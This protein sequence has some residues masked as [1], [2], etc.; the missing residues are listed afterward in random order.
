MLRILLIFLFIY[1]CV[2]VEKH[3]LDEN[4][5]EE[6]NFNLVH[7]DDFHACVDPFYADKSKGEW[8]LVVIPDT[9]HYTANWKKAP[10]RHMEIAFEWIKNM[11]DPLNIEMVQGLGD[12]TE[13]WDNDW[14]WQ[15][16]KKAW[17]KLEGTVAY[18]PVM[19]NH[20]APYKL[21][22][23]FPVSLFNHHYFWGGDFGGIENNYFLMDIGAEKYMFLHIEPYDEYSTYRPEGIKWA[24]K[25]LDKHKNRKAI[26]ATHDNWNTRHIRDQILKYH[27]NVV[28]TNAGHTCA[29]EQ[30]YTTTTEWGGLSHNFITDY[31]CDS[32]EIMLL[33]Y[34]VFKPQEDKV[35][36]YTYSPVTNEFE[37]DHDSYGEFYLHQKN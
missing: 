7:A 33:R 13:S 27:S 4:I 3:S 5:E 29:R 32:Q 25:M 34:Y 23:Y 24:K 1:G 19:G 37:W 10:F 21:N 20:D 12:I 15:N 17:H 6:I 11:K 28:L 22:Q 8:T 26:I 2:A 9:Q 18:M 14:Q 31:Q 35:V 30:Y 16:G 36:F